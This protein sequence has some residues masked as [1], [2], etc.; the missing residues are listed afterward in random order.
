MVV[1]IALEHT[2]RNHMGFEYTE[3]KIKLLD[4]LGLFRAFQRHNVM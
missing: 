4:R 1:P 3:V 2:I